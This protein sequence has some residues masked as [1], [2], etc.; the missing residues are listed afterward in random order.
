MPV[1]STLMAKPQSHN[2]VVDAG[3]EKIHGE[4]AQVVEPDAWTSGM[5]SAVG[6]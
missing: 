6:R 4:V 2:R 5:G 1:V 3:G